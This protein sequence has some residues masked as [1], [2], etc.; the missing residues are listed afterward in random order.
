M[1]Y[2][3]IFLENFKA[4]KEEQRAIIRPL[5]L[6]FGS[7]SA[8]K[9]SFIHSLLLLREAMLTGSL[10]VHYTQLSGDS[11]DLGGYRQYVHGRK[12]NKNVKWGIE[13]EHKNLNESLQDTLSNVRRI[14]VELTFGFPTQKQKNRNTNEPKLIKYDLTTDDVQAVSLT[15]NGDKL[16]FEKINIE[17]SLIRDTVKNIIENYTTLINI[18]SEDYDVLEKEIKRLCQ[19]LVVSEG[20]LLPIGIDNLSSIDINLI[21]PISKASRHDDI[22]SVFRLFFPWILNEILF[23]ISETIEMN[24][25]KLTYLGPLRSYPHRHFTLSYQQDSNWLAGEESLGELFKK[26]KRYG[27]K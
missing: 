7:N 23:G 8:G 27:I 16:K 1:A 15:Y 25:N 4:I 18:S 3:N 24:L 17:N 22:L 19:V 26:I 14:S 12:A 21:H 5:T 13:I 11:V 10:D 20:K 2:F 6:I 9:S